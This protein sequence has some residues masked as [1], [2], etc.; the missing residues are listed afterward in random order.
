MLC[1]RLFLCCLPVCIHTRVCSHD[2][3]SADSAVP[4]RDLSVTFVAL[5]GESVSAAAA[6]ALA[7]ENVNVYFMYH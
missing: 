6:V 5:R 1:L 4:S 2:R 3:Q 7:S